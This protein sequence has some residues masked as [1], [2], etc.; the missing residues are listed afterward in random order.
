MANADT[1]I[2]EIEVFYRA[3]ID[4]FNREDSDAFLESF[5]YPHTLLTGERGML[6]TATASDQRRFH[7]HTMASLHECGWGRSGIDHLQ[8]WP[9]ADALAMIV[10][11]VTRYKKDESV[12]EKV[13]ACYMVRRDGGTWKILTFMEIKPPF[14]GPGV[15]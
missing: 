11:A 7:Q 1:I 10:A 12:L 2:R 6:V 4:G 13:R 15:G 8:V 3:Y 14:P 5:A 9:F